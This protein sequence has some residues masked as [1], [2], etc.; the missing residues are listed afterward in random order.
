MNTGLIVTN[1]KEI[2]RLHNSFINAIFSLSVDA[3]KL[4]LLI[5][6]HTNDNGKNIKI[7]RQDIIEK[8]GIDLKNLS[9]EHREKIIEELMKTIITI[10]DIDNPN[11]F[12]KMQLIYK[13]E[14]ENG[15]LYTNLDED[16]FR[17]N[18]LQ[19]LRYKI[20]SL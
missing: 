16:L 15:V 12:T 17:K 4:L 7:Y 1:D 20:L 10:R 6:L 2:L 9:L 8:I 5:W 19:D 18:F 13:T 3:K 11:N 14:Y